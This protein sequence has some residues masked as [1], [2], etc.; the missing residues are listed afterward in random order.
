[1]GAR[2]EIVTGGYSG[3]VRR[4]AAGKIVIDLDD[5]EKERP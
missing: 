2:W 1:V 4:D 5:D 3:S